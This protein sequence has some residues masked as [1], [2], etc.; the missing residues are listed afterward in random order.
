MNASSHAPQRRV[1]GTFFSGNKLD[2]A[3]RSLLDNGFNKDQIDLLC[4]EEAV[5]EKLKEDYICIS[6][7]ADDEDATRFVEKEG[8][9][10]TVSATIGG[11]SLAGGA[12][13]GGAI[14][15]SAGLLGGPVAVATAASTVAGGLGALAGAFIS[16]SDVDILQ[17]EL[18]AGHIV[19]LVQTQEGRQKDIAQRILT[20]VSEIEAK[21]L[22]PA[23]P[24]N[25]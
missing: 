23:S 22:E 15:A 9:A 10:S 13:G 6:A 12:I 3:I 5:R 11:L 19:L 2:S 25:A 7:I 18:D 1:A 24:V 14:I 20:E 8:T 4:T 16:K 21:V 17:D